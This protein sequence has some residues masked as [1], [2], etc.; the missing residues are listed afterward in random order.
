MCS[1]V[2]FFVKAKYGPLIYTKNL[3]IPQTA[4]Q[5][6]SAQANVSNC[7]ASTQYVTAFS[8]WRKN[9]SKKIATHAPTSVKRL[10]FS[11]SA[12]RAELQE[13]SDVIVKRGSARAQLAECLATVL[14]AQQVA[15]RSPDRGVQFPFRGLR[16]LNKEH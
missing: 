7:E 4:V 15:S 1:M 12:A 5:R 8:S 3:K 11:V 13:E 14:G 6:R 10:P 2:F 16:G 9:D